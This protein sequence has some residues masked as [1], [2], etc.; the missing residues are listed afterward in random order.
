MRAGYIEGVKK[1][2]FRTDL[3]EPQ[4]T[5]PDQVKIQVRVTGICG[6]EIHAYN[7]VHAW[8]V[9][10][11]VSGHEFSG[12]VVE[13]G[14]GVTL[15][16]VGDRVTAE[17]QYGC[18]VCS[19]CRNGRP[20]LCKQKKIL[21]ATYWSG[22]FGEYVVVPQETVIRLSDQV[23]YEEGALMEPVAVGLHAVRHNGVGEDTKIVIIGTGTIGLGV[24]LSCRLMGA[25]DI[26]LVDV[27]DF[28]LEKARELGAVDTINSAREDA[29]ARIMELTQGEGADITFLAFG[30]QPT[31]ELAAKITR[32]GGR[33]SEVAV[34]PKGVTFPLDQLQVKALELVGS[35]MYVREDFQVLADALDQDKLDLKKL[36]TH[37]Y[38]IEE[39]PEAMELMDQHREPVVKI[40]L[41]F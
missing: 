20:N 24:Y 4:I 37:N 2:S 5:K 25:K 27:V 35:N 22:S 30:N 6:S 12:D 14:S 8:R 41:H 28:N 39:M 17:P 21:G 10:P 7:G 18:R 29:E 33:I 11:L 1:A 3:P 23:S 19:Q 31:V 38:P 9:P 15:C 32:G 26:I 36:V 34:I 16:K 40:L 13:V